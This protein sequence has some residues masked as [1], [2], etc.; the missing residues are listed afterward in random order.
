MFGG[1]QEINNLRVC[2][3]LCT[4]NAVASY[5]VPSCGESCCS[6]AVIH[7]REV[8]L[9][10][11]SKHTVQQTCTHRMRPLVEN[12]MQLFFGDRFFFKNSR[13]S[14]K[15]PL[16]AFHEKRSNMIHPPVRGFPQHCKR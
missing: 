8:G 5:H 2:D 15:L 3:A 4:P 10:A 12:S 7:G 9:L 1:T 6:T 13:D 11:S 14:R 16:V